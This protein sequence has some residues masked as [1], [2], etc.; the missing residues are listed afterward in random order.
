M[1]DPAEAFSLAEEALSQAECSTDTSFVVYQPSPQ[2]LSE[3][4]KNRKAANDI[5]TAL[6]EERFTIWHQPIV[7]AKTS[8]PVMYESLLRMKSA[9]GEILSAAHLVPI[10]EKLGFMQMIDFFTTATA[11]QSAG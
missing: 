4:N 10:A 9:D 6:N 1:S 7:S 5:I 8:D 11:A 2:R 3:H